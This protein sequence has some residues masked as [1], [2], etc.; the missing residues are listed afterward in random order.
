MSHCIRHTHS[1]VRA[2]T[3]TLLLHPGKHKLCL[4]SLTRPVT[5]QM[6]R[7]TELARALA[8]ENLLQT[9]THTHTRDCSFCHIYICFCELM[10]THTHEQS[11]SLSPCCRD[12]QIFGSEF[13]LLSD[14]NKSVCLAFC[15]C[16]SSGNIGQSDGTSGAVKLC[17]LRMYWIV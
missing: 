13:E 2:H 7:K 16:C 15:V 8:T 9:H 1:H 3:Y 6:N 11:L 14:W 17:A 5:R 10:F 4:S 12:M